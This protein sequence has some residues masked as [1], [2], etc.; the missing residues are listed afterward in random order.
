MTSSNPEFLRK[1][2][3]RPF[4]M[5]A[6][7][8]DNEVK[9]RWWSTSAPELVKAQYNGVLTRLTG[10]SAIGVFQ[11]PP[12]SMSSELSAAQFSH[13]ALSSTAW[14]CVSRARIA[15]WCSE[16]QTDI[17][18]HFVATHL[19]LFLAKWCVCTMEFE[20]CWWPHTKELYLGTRI[21]AQKTDQGCWLWHS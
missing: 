12:L 2:P 4:S 10:V 19:A 20:C 21:K 8:C 5:R 9:N 3:L 6:C 1:F 15:H 11:Q 17:S 18:C 16:P 14:S 13:H 7:L